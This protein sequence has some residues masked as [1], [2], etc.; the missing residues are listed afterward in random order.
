MQHRTNRATQS[1]SKYPIPHHTHIGHHEHSEPHNTRI[2]TN[3][4]RRIAG[5]SADLFIVMITAVVAPS[6]MPVHA[7]SHIFYPTLVF[8]GPGVSCW[9]NVVCFSLKKT[10]FAYCV[11]RFRFGSLNI[12]FSMCRNDEKPGPYPAVLVV[13]F[14]MCQPFSFFLFCF[15]L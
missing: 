8:W 9:E 11:I 7:Q 6:L 13:V 15:R 3:N 2:S 1:P 4:W 5:K 14:L 10:V 12:K